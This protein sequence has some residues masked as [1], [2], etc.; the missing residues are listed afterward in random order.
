MIWEKM[1]TK[2]STKKIK[3]AI[4]LTRENLNGTFLFL[5]IYILASTVGVVVC[6]L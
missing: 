4:L 3:E 5:F 1:M 2:A 6:S